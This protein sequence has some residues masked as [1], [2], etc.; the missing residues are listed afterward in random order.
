MPEAQKA[1]KLIISVTE[2]RWGDPIKEYELVH[3]K[4]IWV[5]DLEPLMGAEVILLLSAVTLESLFMCIP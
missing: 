3:D 2:H 5:T 1:A 4:L